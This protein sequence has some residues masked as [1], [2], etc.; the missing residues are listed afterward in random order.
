MKLAADG[1][2]PIERRN[3]F[4]SPHGAS[5]LVAED[6]PHDVDADCEETDPIRSLS[7]TSIPHGVRGTASSPLEMEPVLVLVLMAIP[8]LPE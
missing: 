6:S 7:T 1:L 2:S 3:E 8:P 4:S 5:T